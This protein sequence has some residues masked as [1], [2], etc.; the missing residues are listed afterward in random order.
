ML[1]DILSFLVWFWFYSVVHLLRLERLLGLVLGGLCI[2]SFSLYSGGTGGW[3]LG[4]KGMGGRWDGGD[5]EGVG[6]TKKGHERTTE[7]YS[8][9]K[10]NTAR[11]SRPFPSP[12]I[13]SYILD[14]T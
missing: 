11:G 5:Y 1:R 10:T 8:N 4:G 13:Y 14:G 6:G 9:L 2:L 12:S 7:R 3:I